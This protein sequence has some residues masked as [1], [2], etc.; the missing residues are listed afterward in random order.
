MAE[1]K[2]QLIRGLTFTDTTALVIGTVIGTG[3]FIKTAIMAQD[4]GTPGMV[5][6][7][8]VAAGLLSLAGALTY[9]ELGAMLPHAGGEY[10][11]LRHAY[12]EAPAFMY[13]WMRFIVAG[14][15]SIAILGVGFATFLS[16]ILPMTN[17]WAE[18]T[19]TL[20]GQTIKWQ[21]GMKQVVAVAAILFFSIINCFTVAFG[22]RVQSLLTVLKVG[23]IAAVVFGV[24]FFSGTADWSHLATPAGSPVFSG[25][26]VF[27]TAMLAAL[28]A[29]DGWNNMPMA[30]GEVKDPGRNVPRALIIG[31]IVVMLIYCL[32]NLAYFYALPI[33]EV[34]TSN[35]TK[36][37]DA[38]PVATKASQTVFGENGGKLVSIAFILSALGAL[39]GSILTGARV[40]FAM[41]RDGL[42]F[43]KVATLSQGTHVP[44]YAILFQ[45]I[46]ASV[47]AISGTFDQLTDYVIF[48]AWIFYGLVTSSVFVLRR[49]LPDAPRPY[50]TIGY[51]VM[52]LVFVLVAFWLVVNT[53]V[54]RPVESITG[55]ILIA[56]GLPLY[57]Y[58][59]FQKRR[60][61]GTTIVAER[62]Q[63]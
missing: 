36:F 4:T 40:P 3:V 57:L 32:A 9:A 8:W 62:S 49:K 60:E 30:A 31:M 26:A 14:T 25:M 37:R 46:W 42:F 12:G 45:A 44:V 38:L 17:V 35:S 50:K 52:P 2:N 55:L 53:L 51:P 34:L 5:M 63:I 6:A 33:G 22:G 10:V 61:E 23:G 15:G 20:L 24:F 13:G 58:Y 19:F 41:A 1:E 18:S 29:Y 54:N 47:L 11:Y 56:L 16:A 27:G 21:F 28:W 59:R 39:N 43:S 7:A 48:A